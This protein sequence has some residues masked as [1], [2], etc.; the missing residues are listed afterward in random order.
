MKNVT[1]W[2]AALVCLT[3]P[4]ALQADE[5]SVL[6]SNLN[7]E[8]AFTLKEALLKL[9][10]LGDRAAPAIPQL[11]DLL[12]D[13][14]P[15]ETPFPPVPTLTVG[16]FASETLREIGKPA[17]PALVNALS[18]PKYSGARSEVLYTLMR[19]GEPAPAA[20][21]H[22]RQIVRDGQSKLRVTALQTLCQVSPEPEV[23]ILT[24]A[25][26][27][28]SSLLRAVAAT[29]AGALGKP[30]KPLIG[31]LIELLEDDEQYYTGG[32]CIAYQEP[33][34]I[35]AARAL[36][37]LGE[38]ATAAIPRLRK[39]LTERPSIDAAAA[40]LRIEPNDGLARQCVF[41][42]L[43]T[44]QNERDVLI[45]HI[46]ELWR[47]DGTVAFLVPRLIELLRHAEP[48]VR[49][50]ATEALVRFEDP[51][52]EEHFVRLLKDD[53][54]EVR[55]AAVKALASRGDARYADKLLPLL[56]DPDSEVR[57]TVANSCGELELSVAQLT[58]LAARLY[59]QDSPDVRSAICE[60]LGKSGNA[61]EFAV[62]TLEFIAMQARQKARQNQSESRVYAAAE[63]AIRQIR[64]DRG[65]R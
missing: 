51:R 12:S 26:N 47:A 54:A 64:A 16:D 28:P 49:T 29:E 32:A 10:E 23:A 45:L 4:G 15:A 24:E 40:I 38:L 56:D 20:V 62:P 50:A 35:A 14:R 46:R 18:D 3:F 44:P 58:T 53:N 2:I 52:I 9:G 6:L 57:W 37:Q 8:E 17:V 21:P 63:D 13:S 30:A 5:L 41:D 55:M 25:L 42:Q 48:E 61:A 60:V 65:S 19:I 36:G 7:S 1:L 22:L 34:S 11:L 59:D 27:D 31:R 33:V 43:A 39:F